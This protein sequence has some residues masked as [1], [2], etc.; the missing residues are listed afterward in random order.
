QA[1]V[2]HDHALGSLFIGVGRGVVYGLPPL[3][4]VGVRQGTPFYAGYKVKPARPV[5]EIAGRF[6][7]DRTE[8]V[9]Q[10]FASAKKGR[11]WYTLDP[12]AVGAA[13]GEPRERIVRMVDYFEQEGLAEVQVTDARQR[14]TRRVDNADPEALAD[15]LE[16]RFARREAAEVA[17]VGQVAALVEHDGCQTRFLL[18]YFGEAREEPCGHCTWC[19]TGRPTRF[20][21]L[22]ERT[23]IGESLDGA[24]FRRLV[25]ENRE[26]LGHPRQQ[27]RFLCGLSS[28][29]LTRAKLSR[30]PLYG[31]L[32]ERRFA[33]VLAWC[34]EGSAPAAV[35]P[36]PVR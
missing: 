5:E 18:A 27:A 6:P 3:L 31:A 8:F 17:R 28:P 4:G 30:H 14:Y 15:E 20:P 21:A 29:A 33:E 9:R 7:P 24:A 19:E 23:P 35:T 16:A 10:V 2:L 13:L 22:P 26:A 34:G 32:E 36:R 11:E 12:A 1:L 25:A